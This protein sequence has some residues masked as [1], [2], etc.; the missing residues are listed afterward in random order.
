MY[1]GADYLEHR[2]ELRAVRSRYFA[3]PFPASTLVQ[4]AGFANPDYLI[5]VEAVA[6]LS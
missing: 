3:E 4:V 5:E 6:A 1:V 2:A